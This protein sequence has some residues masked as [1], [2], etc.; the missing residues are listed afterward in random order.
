MTRRNLR[1][2]TLKAAAARTG[3]SVDR[4]RRAVHAGQIQ[5]FREPTGTGKGTRG[6]Y[7]LLETSFEAWFLSHVTG[8]GA[9]PEEAEVEQAV[10]EA[11]DPDA[12]LL[13]ET[14]V[15]DRFV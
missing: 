13:A 3:L 4:I 7:F 8:T 5:A 1:T 2:L 10:T 11:L 12:A 14:P 6:T 15:E 9:T